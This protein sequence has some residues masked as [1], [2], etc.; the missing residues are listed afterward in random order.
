MEGIVAVAIF[1]VAA[2]IIGALFVFTDERALRQRL[3]K[4]PRKAIADVQKNEVVKIVGR[5]ELE[6]EPLHAPLSG[7]ECALFD[8]LVREKRGR[9]NSWYTV[10]RETRMR[11]FFVADDSGRA[12]VRMSRVEVLVVRDEHQDSG[13]LDDATPEQEA[14]LAR[15]G[16]YTEG[17]IMNRTLRYEEGVLEEG[18]MVAVLGRAR[19]ETVDG[20]ERLVMEAIDSQNALV[21]SDDPG[22]L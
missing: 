4:A 7:R 2:A 5:L 3:I 11:E 17:V 16:Q 6:G 21:A 8:V 15:H 10:I 12:R 13:F 22:A 1:V 19:W 20:E 18:E 9:G 14:Y